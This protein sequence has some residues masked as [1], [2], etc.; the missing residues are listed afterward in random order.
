M[1]NST[2]HYPIEPIRAST[3][4][5]LEGWEASEG[6]TT[7][8]SPEARRTGLWIRGLD[9]RFRALWRGG[10]VIGIGMTDDMENTAGQGKPSLSL[11]LLAATLLADQYRSGVPKKQGSVAPIVSPM[12]GPATV[13][14]IA[15]H[16]Y[17]TI[18][19]LH[20]LLANTLSDSSAAIELLK[21]VQL[22]QYFDFAGLAEAV[23]EISEAVYRRTQ[24]DKKTYSAHVQVNDIVLIQGLGQTMTTTQRRSGHVHGNALL[25]GLTRNIGQLSRIARDV[26][27]LID[28]PIE[29]GLASV[30]NAGQET[31][32][33]KRYATGL[34]VCSAFTG[35]RGES[36]RL[37]CGNETLSRTLEDVFD[38]MVAVHDGF[39]RVKISIKEQRKSQ[40]QIVEVI[41]DRLG[42]TMGLWAVWTSNS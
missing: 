6:S 35:P 18:P 33:A 13:Y 38:C 25:A 10:R 8:T 16:T 37:L 7:S 39:G 5:D 26:L 9:T 32:P 1:A 21:G 11:H 28:A 4:L 15:P 34:E 12:L 24:Q 41:K 2:S 23:A 31:P 29:V 30:Q 22:L 3:L 27:I 36:L 20:A 19:M 14:I 17:Q 40:E 42:D